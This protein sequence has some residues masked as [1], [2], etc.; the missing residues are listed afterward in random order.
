MT[1]VSLILFFF[2]FLPQN[3]LFFNVRYHKHTSILIYIRMSASW[4]FTGF[5]HEVFDLMNDERSIYL[6]A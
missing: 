1:V 5:N 4:S 6:K 3:S 2:R